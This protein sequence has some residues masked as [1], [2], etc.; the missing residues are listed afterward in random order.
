VIYIVVLILILVCFFHCATLILTATPLLVVLSVPG[1]GFHKEMPMHKQFNKGNTDVPQIQSK[2]VMSSSKGPNSQCR[3]KRVSRE[4]YGK[5]KEK[6][7]K[8]KYM[9]AGIRIL[10]NVKAMIYI[11]FK[12]QFRNNNNYI[13]I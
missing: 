2:S 10:L 12:L 5:S 8:T 9:P 11:K 3:Y 6:Y 1:F 4:V 13:Y 7:F